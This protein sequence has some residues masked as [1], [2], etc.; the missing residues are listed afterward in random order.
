[1]V[2]KKFWLG[3]L[4]MVLVF[5]MTVIGCDD[6]ST[7]GSETDT[8][9]NV[10]SFSQVNGTWKAQATVTGNVQG[11][12]ITQNYNNY[13]I[14]FNSNTQT[15]TASGTST[16][17]ISGGNIN[18]IWSDFKESLEYMNEQDGVTVTFNDTNHSYTMTCNNSS[19]TLTNSQLT[20]MGAQINQNETKLKI[21]S[22]MGFE[23]I[24][25][26]Q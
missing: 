12:K 1:M 18:E 22:G 23:I 7:G 17:T 6:S 15:M 19:Q 14:T 8:W 20:E 2:N 4:V 9:S 3:I 24:Y 11:M 10:T 26:K 5:G 25:T 21:D 13:T 16:T